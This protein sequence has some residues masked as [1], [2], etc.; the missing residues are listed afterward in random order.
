[1][2]GL[3]SGPSC[4]RRGIPP[5]GLWDCVH[6]PRPACRPP[7]ERSGSF[8]QLSPFQSRLRND[9]DMRRLDHWCAAAIL[10]CRARPCSSDHV[11]KGPPKPSARCARCSRIVRRRNCLKAAGA[12]SRPARARCRPRHGLPEN[13]ARRDQTFLV[14]ERDAPALRDGGERRPEAGRPHD[15]GH[16]AIG[17][18]GR[19]LHERGAAGGGL[20]AASRQAFLKRAIAA[21]VGDDRKGR[22]V[23]MATPPASACGWRAGQYSNMAE[24]RPMTST[25]LAYDPVATSTLTRVAD[26]LTRGRVSSSMRLSR[27]L[28]CSPQLS[29]LKANQ[30]R[31]R[32]VHMIRR[33][34]PTTAAAR[35]HPS[36]PVMTPP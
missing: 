10:M 25:C 14:G 19:R 11:R 17:G 12:P 24:L 9:R 28:A 33:G 5:G 16:Y 34:E 36:D 27:A 4:S 1:M 30:Q 7:P 3:A 15:A 32:R 35:D 8:D 2:S 20:D 21:L 31:A 26:L 22:A 13:L 18:K 23:R 6:Q 29:V